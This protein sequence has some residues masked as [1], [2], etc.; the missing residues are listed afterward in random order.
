MIVTGRGQT[1][2]N[3]RRRRGGRG[4][5]AALILLIQMVC[6]VAST[7]DA[8]AAD[9][10]AGLAETVFQNFSRDLGLPHPVP[11]A[12]AQDPDGFLWVGT[13]GGLGRWDGYRFRG[14]KPDPNAPGSLPDGWIR[15]LH[16]DARGQ[17]W[18]GTS[19]GGLAR[20]DR[21]HDRF[22][23]VPLSSETGGH[24][25][26]GAIADDGAGGLWIGTDDGLD[27]LDPETGSVAALHHDDQDRL[28]VPDGPI[29]ALLRDGKGRLWVGTTEGLARRDP[30]ADRFAPIALARPSDGALSVSALFEDADG[31]IWI[32]TTRHGVY[33]LGPGD[34]EPRAFATVDP[35]G[36]TLQNDW[37]SAISAAGSHEIW[38]ATRG[39]GI[40][41]VDTATGQARRIRHDRTLPD[42]LAHD[43]VWALLQ[44]SAGSM[45]AGGTG[46][47]SYRPKSL[48]VVSTVFGASD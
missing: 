45:W 39:A 17:L 26:I 29:Q 12:L 22:A 8:R 42:S 37:I 36:S 44:D 38:I 15:T 5:H 3:H 6:L 18:I 31:Q 11:T 35:T 41:A 47:L 9:R 24:R 7:A 27:R 33:I 20:Y 2:L 46:G 19:V 40:V 10:W 23:I 13:Q 28:S 4:W 48:G 25:H 16:I 32:G 43:D 14:Y 30:D 34:E 1:Q 21:E